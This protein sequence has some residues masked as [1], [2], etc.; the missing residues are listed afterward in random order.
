MA[1]ARAR[2]GKARRSIIQR[3][4]QTGVVT[5]ALSALSTVAAF[6][7]GQVKKA[8]T[9][10][11]EYETGY[12]ALGG[13]GF[14]RPK[15]GKGYFKGPEGEVSIGEGK[16]R[17][18]YDR[19]QIQKAGSFL[20]SEAAGILDQPARD[21]YLQRTAPGRADPLTGELKSSLTQ[22][23]GDTGTGF[24]K[25]GGMGFKGLKT[26]ESLIGK[27]LSSTNMISMDLSKGKAYGYGKDY[28]APTGVQH[29]LTG[30]DFQPFV[31]GG[32]R[33]RDASGTVGIQ[34]QQQEQLNLMSQG[35]APGVFRQT[36]EG[37]A[38]VPQDNSLDAELQR[39]SDTASVADKRTS[40][41]SYGGGGTGIDPN[42]Q[43]T[44]NEFI[45][46]QLGGYTEP[47]SAS[48]Y[49]DTRYGEYRKRLNESNRFRGVQSYARGGDFITNGPQKIIV[50]DNA[51]GRERVTVKPLP[52]KNGEAKFGRYGDDSMKI[53]DGQPAHIDSSIEGDMS[54]E[55][56]KKYGSGTIN[57]I[58]GKKEYFLPMVM[59][60]LAIGSSLYK[61]YQATQ[62]KADVD[63]GI[64]AAGDIRQ[65]Q[66]GFAGEQRAIAGQTAELGLDVTESQIAAGGRE[67]IM[68]A[69]TA[70]GGVQDFTT[71]ATT[72]SNLV[73]SGTIEQKS[74]IQGKSIIEGVKSDMT[75]LFETR[76]LAGRERDIQLTR[77]DLSEEERKSIIEDSYQGTLTGLESTQTGFLEG[78]FS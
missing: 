68:G 63:A 71:T 37:G 31:A 70:M 27:D 53:I 50:G 61:G 76:E 23:T 39:Q 44:G 17:R 69:K 72:K 3:K 16:L 64:T 35:R 20:S 11:G 74:A 8:K 29:E 2:L 24:G 9:A 4:K 78:M 59:A 7:A 48:I 49:P 28:K 25:G 18:T 40:V 77:A 15:I 22:M 51:S 52:S 10:W 1:N 30:K 58:T 62:N 13:E 47:D 57:P 19:G 56:I 26:G 12:E 75:K 42:I 5:G 60:G 38:P 45:D 33:G 21:R 46:R 34:A 32:E 67:S 14:E 66:L 43:S 65:E 54:P 6:G 73:T 41:I 36:R 55:D